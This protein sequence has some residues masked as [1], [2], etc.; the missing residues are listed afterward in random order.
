MIRKTKNLWLISLLIVAASLIGASTVGAQDEDARRLWDGAFL[1]KRAE[2]KTPAPAR[3][4]TAYRRVTPKKPAAPNP[5]SQSSTAQNPASQNPA[6]Q[7]PAS[8]NP[9]A[10]NQPNVK[11]EGELV[12]LTIWR[13]RPSRATDGQETRLLIEDESNKDAEWT[14][15][16]VEADTVFA[17]GDRV[18]LGIES[19]RDGY[20]YVIDREQYTDGTV[21]DPYLIFP[22][23]RNR[24]GAN[25]V[26]A[27]KVIELPERAAFRLKPMRTDYAGEVLTVL[28][29][30]E[31]LTDVKPESAPVKLDPVKVAGWESQWAAAVERF[32]LIGGA[33]KPYTKAEKEA[34]Q[35]G[36][37]ILTQDDAM[38]QTL[39]HVNVKR[40]SPLLVT[41]PLRIG[42]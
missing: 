23:L 26:S 37:R 19:P 14:P 21:S 29:T 30:S 31:P 32:E 9:A 40:G 25:S 2:S 15:E 6:S 41:V 3:K 22:S 16:R 35:E 1:K 34:G 27:G 17:P 18:R 10:Q 28:V 38:P 5:A 24:D 12:G 36:A 13:L 42:R 4:T 8:Q 11:A 7:N 20:L 39:Y 33:G